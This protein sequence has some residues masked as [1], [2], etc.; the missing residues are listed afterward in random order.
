MPI[1]GFYE[2]K[3]EKNEKIPYRIVSNHTPIVALAGLYEQWK[4]EKSEVIHSFTIITTEANE[5]M[6]TIHN[7]MPATLLPHQE[8]EWLSGQLSAHDA[9]ETL[10]QYPDEYL[11]IYRVSS[12]V[13]NVRNNYPTLIKRVDNPPERDLFSYIKK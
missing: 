3:K 10:P 13:N 9:L 8:S 4:N 12:E 7:R 5:K 2:W 1:D 6:K 11:D